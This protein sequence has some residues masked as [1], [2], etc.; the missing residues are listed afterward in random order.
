MTREQETGA[1]SSRK[2]LKLRSGIP[3]PMGA[4][5][6]SL[7]HE[8]QHGCTAE[9]VLGPTHIQYTLGHLQRWCQISVTE[10]VL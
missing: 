10:T 1:R 4:R 7:Q 3:A 9:A 5:G 8:R 6:C 2:T